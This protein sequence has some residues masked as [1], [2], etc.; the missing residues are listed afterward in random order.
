LYVLDEAKKLG[1]KT[2]VTDR[3]E[4][5]PCAKVADVFCVADIFDIP[6]HVEI[7]EKLKSLMVVGVIAAGVD[8]NV[9]ASYLD[10]EVYG[11]YRTATVEVADTLHNK[12]KMRKAMQWLGLPVPRFVI[13][14]DPWGLV[15]G[16]SGF[17][18]PFI[19]KPINNSGGRGMSPFLHGAS[20]EAI[21]AAYEKAR[22]ANKGG[23]KRVLMESMWTGTEHTVETLWQGGTMYPCFITDRE[24]DAVDGV[25]RIEVGLRNPTI[26]PIWQQRAIFR[27]TN[28]L[29]RSLGIT[30]GALKLD[31][32]VD[33]TG[34]KILEATTR[35][36][37]GWDWAVLN[38][39][40]TGMNVGRMAIR[41]AIG[42]E[43]RHEFAVSIRAIKDRVALSG[44][45]W[46]EPGKKITKILST[47]AE[48]TPGLKMLHFR[49]GPGDVIE[50][51][52][53]STKRVCFA[54]VVG[55]SYSE[56]RDTLTR[57]LK[58]ILIEVE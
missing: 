52:V 29:G 37:G 31:I 36:S 15:H 14:D 17:T 26:L 22:E 48:K 11:F 16:L 32:I 51:Y 34:P 9:T 24:F 45:V 58:S 19:V 3:D 21:M 20:S 46:P 53:D 55:D 30:D 23:D 10:N 39:A 42:E 27:M 40:A 8:A 38:R 7:A 6:A 28:D 41:V 4:K 25:H 2:I 33:E 18:G 44:S 49:Y 12:A 43:I 1:L 56:A 47:I 13:A 50:P 35:L 54:F 5:C 57:I